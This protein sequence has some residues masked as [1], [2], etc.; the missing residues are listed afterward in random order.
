[1]GLDN[2]D[3]IAEIDRTEAVDAFYRQSGSEIVLEPI[4]PFIGGWWPDLE[5]TIEFC[6]G[7]ARAGA[8]ILGAFADG[9]LIA[10]VMLTP[11]IEPG[12]AQLSFLQ[13]SAAHRRQG[14]AAR[15]LAEILE[16]AR[17]LGHRSIYVTATPTKSAVGF[18]RKAGFTPTADVI[19][20]LYDLEPE[21]IH[22]VAVL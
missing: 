15:L 2:L 13:V 9:R 18:Y 3:R 16:R 17:V 1:M 6:R 19:Q 14:I 11:N 7:H 4:E 20:R 12:I 5:T 22:M 21:D 8:E 10:I